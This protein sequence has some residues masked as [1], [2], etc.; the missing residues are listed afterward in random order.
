MTTNVLHNSFTFN[1]GNTG[2]Q[3]LDNVFVVKPANVM[4]HSMKN[5]EF[6]NWQPGTLARALVNHIFGPGAD[7]SSIN[8]KTIL[9]FA[10]AEIGWSLFQDHEEL[11]RL[12]A[13][14][15]YKMMV[16]MEH[17]PTSSI[18]VK[19]FTRADQREAQE[20][21]YDSVGNSVPSR[22]FKQVFTMISKFVSLKFGNKL[23]MISR[24]EAFKLVEQVFNSASVSWQLT[25][26][27]SVLI[28]CVRQPTLIDMLLQ[29]VKHS[30]RAERLHWALMITE[31]MCGIVNVCPAATPGVIENMRQVLKSD[32]EEVLIMG[33]SLY[34]ALPVCQT[35][36]I[37][38]NPE[39]VQY[40]LTQ[41]MLSPDR[42]CEYVMQFS[43]SS[44]SCGELPFIRP[45]AQ[46]KTERIAVPFIRVGG[47]RSSEVPILRV[48]TSQLEHNP[49]ED[50]SLEN[51]AFSNPRGHK[52][53]YF[54][55][56]CLAPA[57]TS[58]RP[59]QIL[60]DR[61]GT[62][63]T[64]Q[65]VMK[66]SPNVSNIIQHDGK[67]VKV[68]STE[69]HKQAN[70]PDLFSADRARALTKDMVEVFK[71]RPPVKVKELARLGEEESW[72]AKTSNPAC[73]LE[74]CPRYMAIPSN[75]EVPGNE[76][77][78]SPDSQPTHWSARPRV[79]LF[80]SSMMNS[81][82]GEFVQIGS[83]LLGKLGKEQEICIGDYLH[84]IKTG[85]NNSDG[86]DSVLKVRGAAYKKNAFKESCETI[87]KSFRNGI[88]ELQCI[89]SDPIS[90]V[91]TAQ[92]F[93][94]R[95]KPD[96]SLEKDHA[97]VLTS[98]EEFQHTLLEIF[99]GVVG[100][101]RKNTVVASLPLFCDP[102]QFTE[103]DMGGINK[104]NYPEYFTQDD[105]DYCNLMYWVIL[106]VLGARV[107]T[108]GDAND[109]FYQHK[110]LYRPDDANLDEE[111]GTVDNK[112]LT[113]GRVK[114]SDYVFAKVE[115]RNYKNCS[116][117][118]EPTATKPNRVGDPGLSS[119][120]VITYIWAFRVNML[121]KLPHAV[122]KVLLAMHY[123]TLLTRRVILEHYDKD[124]FSGVSYLL[125][126]GTRFQGVGIT[127][128]GQKSVLY[129]LGS[130]IICFPTDSN[131]HREI[132]LTQSCESLVMPEGLESPGI[133]V[134]NMF[135]KNV[136]GGDVVFSQSDPYAMVVTDA[137][138][139]FCPESERSA[140]Y[141]RPFIFIRGR[142]Q[143]LNGD[144]EPDP[145][146]GPGGT[147][148]YTCMPTLLRPFSSV[149]RIYELS[150]RKQRM[151]SGPVP[152][153]KLFSEVN[154]VS[155]ID[156]YLNELNCD[157]FADAV[158]RTKSFM[159]PQERLMTPE[160]GVAFCGTYGLGNH[161]DLSL[162]PRSPGETETGLV[163]ELSPRI[164]GTGLY[165]YTSADAAKN[166]MGIVLSRIIN[167]S[168]HHRYI[169]H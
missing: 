84:I 122:S 8:T 144:L 123:T 94:E 3:V 107:Y 140:G 30:S 116:K 80:N 143:D 38:L 88:R 56:G 49:D 101:R 121:K 21:A 133:H 66:R 163:S 48:D 118:F 134:P 126:R 139:G 18:L 99:D 72:L 142:S 39:C 42:T 35:R 112:G 63:L 165:L 40:D 135:M 115:P 78:V 50:T 57:L 85:L 124:Y 169:S 132:T 31:L 36:E 81:I 149:Y 20:G 34:R 15:V 51:T 162:K 43:D 58:I 109:S 130:K 156:D 137:F 73:V 10:A 46:R 44:S 98:F 37:E 152:N 151:G 160:L 2:T 89:M 67:I 136:V 16:P 97:L 70:P 65:D 23:T 129:T 53:E 77:G 6:L 5:P 147:I 117:A 127:L 159:L 64:Y 161:S 103:T 69:V 55:L 158:N 68:L 90:A 60:C 83:E 71:G 104:Y 153:I 12:L 146:A 32:K 82:H 75:A 4:K 28:Y 13:G 167:I 100:D 111:L 14:L 9:Q 7:N 131:S 52:W 25:K 93:T 91:F 92:Y 113:V 17:V 79:A 102:P 148:S 157:P 33:Q 114:G 29:R 141:R 96:G 62:E 119:S 22:E 47:G 164:S 108:K 106:P 27:K 110:L 168:T 59:G 145:L 166:I 45:T 155:E 76:D 54:T 61:S 120:S 11:S 125:F 105:I 154:P 87:E 19:K 1:P 128:M 150:K 26:I 74:F 24:T 95:D 138:N 41:E 86:A